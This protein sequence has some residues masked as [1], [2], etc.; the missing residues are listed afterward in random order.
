MSRIWNFVYV[1]TMKLVIDHKIVTLN[2]SWIQCQL[3][4][5]AV[6]MSQCVY[7]PAGTTSLSLSDR[8]RML[9]WSSVTVHE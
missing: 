7:P 6:L 2:V 1:F 5:I 3:E 9:V 4:V 8:N